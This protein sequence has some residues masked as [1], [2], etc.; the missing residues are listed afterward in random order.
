MSFEPADHADRD[1]ARR[2][3]GETLVL[4]AGAGTGKTTLLVDRIESLILDGDARVT[5]IAA[6]TFTENAAATLK[7]RLRERLERA[8]ARADLPA[9]ARERAG[10]A[11]DTLERAQVSTIHALCASILQERPLECGV[12]PGFRTADE[13]QAEALFAEAWDEWLAGRLD[14]SD[15]VLAEAVRNEIPLM[16][17]AGFGESSS[18]RGLARTLLWQRDLEP[19]VSEAAPDPVQWRGELVEQAVRARALREAAVAGDALGDAL[20]R[21]EAFAESCRFLS[22]DALVERLLDVPRLRKDVGR[23]GNWRTAEALQAARELIGWVLDA[24]T[25]WRGAL[26]SHLHAELTRSLAGVLSRYEVK[27]RDAGVLDFVDLLVRTRDALRDRESVR[28]HARERFRFL[29]IDEFQD[30]DPLQVEIA[31]LLASGEPGR[32]VVVGDAK[33]SIYRFRRADVALFAR[34]CAQARERSGHAVLRLNQNFRSRPGVL[35]FVNRAFAPLITFSEDADQ[36]AYEPIEPPPGLAA[37]PGV[38]ALR[39]RTESPL[40]SGASL[41]DAEADAVAAF[42]AQA[43]AGG[44]EVRDPATGARRPSR[45]GDV[46][47]LAPR[48]TQVRYLED[49]LD[50]HG[51]ACAVDGG[52]SFFN[53]QEVHEALATLRAIDDRADTVSLVAALR[54][55]FLGVSDRDLVEHRL[56]GFDLGI[57]P[58]PETAPESMRAALG[59]LGDL[60]DERLR[61]SVPGLIERLYDRTRVLAALTGTRRGEARIANLEKVAALARQS[62]ELGALTL[63]GFTRLLATRMEESAEEPDL[64]AT[65]PGDPDTVRILSIH[66]AKGLEAPIVVLYDL[67]ARLRTL[68]DVIALWDRGQV[69]VGFRAGC[70]PPGWN[71]LAERD[72]AR[73]RAEGRRLLYVACTRARDWLVVPRPPRDAQIGDFWKD[74]LPFLDGAPAEVEVVDADTLPRG[75]SPRQPLDT[76][77][78]AG[79]SGGDAAAARWEAERKDLLEA[80]GYRPYVPIAAVRAALRDAPSEGV[81]EAS[82]LGRYFGSLVHRV[83][84]WVPL[85]GATA[86][87]VGAMAQ[88]LAPSFG[89]DG[90]AG[91]RAGEAA[92]SALRLPVMER[93]RTARR[94]WRELPLFFPDG[95]DLIE[96]VID[97]VFEEDAGLVIVDYKTDRIGPEQ[98]VAQAAHHAPQ[99]QLYGRGLAQAW[100]RPV[101]ERLVLFTSIGQSVRV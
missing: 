69:A 66:K 34:L 95:G 64:P 22:G 63:R 94:V 44:R 93:A 20:Q 1:R 4:E 52:K 57:G 15:P 60:H 32:L 84:E 51:V 26:G 31:E 99:L 33:Q 90:E 9:G 17:V 37:G 13:A 8:R 46:M 61:V 72:A 85:D 43:A 47:V 79:A 59:L 75:T 28:A 38:V 41:R 21:V 14:A 6:V 88:A 49:A 40:A 3:R 80:G 30:T 16:G 92:W 18:L 70:R 71:E 54:S 48:L 58:A 76:R 7:L 50:E 82:P 87:V 35:A 91:R 78:L 2:S 24:E 67:D 23:R 5:E 73:A 39:F 10:A 53:R 77:A 100:G 89:L 97:L 81:G 45:A 98:A 25:R 19:L 55:S 74:L 12:V 101:V 29:L 83:L 11:L 56:R 27:K 68:T 65:R 36:P 62:A 96:G 86:D 42:I